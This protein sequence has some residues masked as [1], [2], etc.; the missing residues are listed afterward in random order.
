M[1]DDLS[2]R[3]LD[4]FRFF[5]FFCLFYV[6][7]CL[8]YEN[9]RKYLYVFGFLTTVIIYCQHRKFMYTFSPFPKGSLFFVW[10]CYDEQKTR[11]TVLK[12]LVLF[13][14]LWAG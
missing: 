1:I 6:R 3:V 12:K 14:S 5:F 8:L 9:G 10:I 13:F 2:A 7:R 11:S 4:K